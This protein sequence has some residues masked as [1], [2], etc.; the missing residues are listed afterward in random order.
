MYEKTLS[1]L[2]SWTVDAGYDVSYSDL[3]KYFLSHPD[4]GTI[5]SIT[6]TFH[7]LKIPCQAITIEAHNLKS[8]K[9]PFIAYIQNSIQDY[10]V[11]VTPKK[12]NFFEINTGG[13][14]P[15]VFNFSD[16]EKAFLGV[17]IVIDKNE[18]KQIHLKIQNKTVWSTI[19]L[20]LINSVLLF[21]FKPVD[22]SFSLF[23]WLSLFG[24]GFSILLFQY[25]LSD[26]NPLLNRFCTINE[27][28]SCKAVINSDF[29]KIF[30][31]YTFTDIGLLYFSFQ[32]LYSLVNM[33]FA[34]NLLYSI[35]ILSLFFPLYSIYVQAFLIKKFCPLC[36]GVVGV[37]I[38]Q[39]LIGFLEINFLKLSF[40]V[41][42][43]ISAFGIITFCFCF[44]LNF[45]L[46]QK[47]E[48]ELYSK[49]VEL[50]AFKR[51]YYLF[52]PFYKEASYVEPPSVNKKFQIKVGETN[53]PIQITLVT[54]PLCK[55]CQ[56]AHKD[57]LKIYQNF[58]QDVSIN[59]LFYVP[60]HNIEDPR[61]IIASW[62]IK[63]YSINQEKGIKIIDEWYNT[64][65]INIFN[66][67]EK[68]FN[69]IP[70]TVDILKVHNNWCNVNEFTITPT[71]LINNKLFPTVYQIED[72]R[73]LVESI[74]QF[75]RTQQFNTVELNTVL[76]IN[77]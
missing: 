24:L 58:N 29:S 50:L 48:Q 32:I 27:S 47:K 46:M 59:Y 40:S 53:A 55:S 39:G 72:L 54:N 13:Q 9:E 71:I 5:S 28:S 10:F 42:S 26:K 74:S 14:K 75:E 44:L 73:F 69:I 30:R 25:N 64:N 17:I 35:S 41:Y 67:K 65:D 1:I 34:P 23:L 4:V 62:L 31:S 68:A 12:D 61:T 45:K 51:N 19:I 33:F 11:L 49:E 37:I 52:L 63:E 20:L 43:L 66:T 3:Q 70:E 76:A 22:I 2:Q 18:K 6:D 36:L 57:L 7:D 16:L 77:T 56:K 38:L 8:L 21:W 60:A 15:F